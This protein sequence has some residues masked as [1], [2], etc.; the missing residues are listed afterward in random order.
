VSENLFD[1]H[2]LFGIADASQQ[3]VTVPTSIE[4][5]DDQSVAAF[6]QWHSIGRWVGFSDVNETSP[7]HRFHGLSPCCEPPADLRVF[8]HRMSQLNHIEQFRMFTI[9]EVRPEVN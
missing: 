4:Y 6:A 9:C 5:G 2:N 7:R 1:L 3:P 8:Y